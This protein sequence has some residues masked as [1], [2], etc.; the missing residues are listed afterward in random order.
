LR[1]PAAFFGKT[2]ERNEISAIAVARLRG[3]VEPGEEA[4]QIRRADLRDDLVP[5]GAAEPPQ[6]QAQ[7]A[8]VALAS[9]GRRFG[10]NQSVRGGSHRHAD[11]LARCCKA[12]RIAS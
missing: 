8:A 5:V 2:P 6:A 10:I 12:K 9:P 11:C 1:R 7:V 3:H 4:F